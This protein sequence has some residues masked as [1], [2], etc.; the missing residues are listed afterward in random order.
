MNIP[1]TIENAGIATYFD[2]KTVGTKVLDK[3]ALMSILYAAVEAADF[4]Q[5]VPGQ[6]F[7]PLPPGTESYVS[8]GVGRRTL[9]PKDFH[10]VEYNGVVTQF[11]KRENAAK[12]DSVAAIVYTLAAYL[13]DPDVIDDP[14]L[15]SAQRELRAAERAR[16]EKSNCTH[17][18][19]ALLASVG[20]KPPRSSASFVAG[21]A[22]GNNEFAWMQD[23]TCPDSEFR[24]KIEGLTTDAAE[25]KEYEKTWCV[26]AD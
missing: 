18:L 8:G 15:T 1:I 3:E 21:I 20:P 4:S 22:G 13:V 17:V 5:G 16:I 12:P 19:V 10:N 6:A 26:V 23:Y 25:V 11:L 7:I 14:D 2:L 9:D 24:K